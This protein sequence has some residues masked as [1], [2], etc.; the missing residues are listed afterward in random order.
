LAYQWL[1]QLA[2]DYCSIVIL[3]FS[4]AAALEYQHLRKKYPRLGS[5]D[6]RIAAIT[7]TN[8]AILLT[9]NTSDFQQIDELQIN[10]WSAM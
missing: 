3:S 5:M 7:L 2:K 1:Q 8:N 9:R 10:D 6:L 4:H